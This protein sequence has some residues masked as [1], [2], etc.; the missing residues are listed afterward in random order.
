MLERLVKIFTSLRLTV[1]LLGLGAVLVFW[2]TLA[3]VDLGLYKAQNEFFR[4][5]IIFWHPAGAGWRIPIFP[6]GYLVG[7]L[8]LINLFSAHLR[9][10]QPGKKKYGIIMIHLGIVLL[11][12]GQLLTD[13]LS[14]E[15]FMHV[16]EGAAKNFSEA[17]RD[18]E[19]AVIDTT[20]TDSDKVVAIPGRLLGMRGEISHPE[21]PFRIKVKTIYSHSA[22]SEEPREGYAPVNTTAGFGAK[23][24]WRELPHVTVMEDK[25]IPSGIV[26]LATPQAALG[27]FL[28]SGF[29]T[30]PQEFEHNGRSYRMELRPTRSYKPFS[31]RLLEFRFDRYPGTDTPKNYSSRVRVQRPDTGEDRE[32]LIKM[33]S[34]LRYAGETFYQASFDKDDEKGTVLQVVHNPSWLTPYFSC[35]LVAAGMIYQFLSHLIAFATKRKTA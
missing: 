1:T 8:L 12:L 31:L 21:M 32:V 13:L 20:D 29:L 18:F 5:F 11:L 10:Y 7:G 3:Q 26:E 15:S 2:G 4:S 24:W 9:Y 33:N 14:N 19:L 35:V 28:V 30:R 16:R 25:D 34:P 27:T 6:G 17:S 22:L 23:I